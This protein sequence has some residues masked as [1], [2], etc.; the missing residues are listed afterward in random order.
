MDTINTQIVSTIP[1]V[2]ITSLPFFKGEGTLTQLDGTVYQGSFHNHKRHGE[3]I[4]VTRLVYRYVFQVSQK[5]YTRLV[6][7]EIKVCG[8]YSKLKC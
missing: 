5:K 7:Y 3:G 2:C 4:E 8:Q 6:G 1:M